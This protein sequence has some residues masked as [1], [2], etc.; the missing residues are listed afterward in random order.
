MRDFLGGLVVK[1]PPVSA[2]DTGSIPRQGRFHV[3]RSNFAYVPQKL[4]PTHPGA[5]ACLNER[6]H[7]NK[8]LTHLNQRAA[9]AFHNW[10][11][12]SCSHEDPVQPKINK[13]EKKVF[14][15]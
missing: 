4:K 3:A 12:P 10:R 11:K 9:P 5:N 1:N 14:S 6:S 2:E 15:Y 7:C 13:L 8:K